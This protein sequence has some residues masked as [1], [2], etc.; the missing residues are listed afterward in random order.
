MYGLA[1]AVARWGQGPVKEQAPLMNCDL[2]SLAGESGG[3]AE[4]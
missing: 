2:S 4:K 3:D 1:G